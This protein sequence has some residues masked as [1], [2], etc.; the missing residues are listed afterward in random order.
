MSEAD[1]FY[2]SVVQ[3]ALRYTS[4]DDIGI[5]RA[6]NFF[7]RTPG[8]TAPVPNTNPFRGRAITGSGPTDRDL[9][10]LSRRYP[11][12]SGAPGPSGSRPNAINFVSGGP[13]D[14]H[15][16]RDP[17]DRAGLGFS[18]LRSVT[19]IADRNML[20]AAE[21][22]E[23]TVARRA[24]G[25]AL[26][27]S[28]GMSLALGAMGN[29]AINTAGRLGVEGI[30]SNTEKEM[31]TQ[32]ISW[33]QTKLNQ[34][35]AQ[36][37]TMQSNTFN[38]QKQMSAQEYNQ[39]LGLQNNATSN[40]ENLYTF[41]TTQTSNALNEAGL[42]TYLAYLP[43]A[44]SIQPKTSQLSASGNY[45]YTSKIPGNPQT[46]AFADTT[47]SNALGWGKFPT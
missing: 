39:Q 29:A 4:A 27:S 41:Q 15:T 20:A 32:R 6:G 23:G 37:L 22:A 44:M 43:G 9:L 33:N 25:R 24:G 7:R 2:R 1:N 5:A 28:N 40:A 38:Q 12:S 19:E 47:T 3:R 42:P 13:L 45:A 34:Q 8:R 17:G 14:A 21:G 18:P 30:R 11:V 26:Q 16:A 31:Q 35:Q 36:E 10:Q 46:S